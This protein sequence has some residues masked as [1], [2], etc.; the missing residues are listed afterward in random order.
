MPALLMLDRLS[1]LFWLRYIIFR[2]SLTG[3]REVVSTVFRLLVMTGYLFLSI[4]S[5]VTIFLLI[6]LK[7]DQL[8]PLLAGSMGTLFGML[9]FMTLI[10]QATG[11]SANFDPR[12]FMLF[13]ISLRMLFGLNLLS[14]F[15]EAVMITLLPTVAGI[16]LGLG[17]AFDQ[18]LAGFL[19]FLSAAIWLDSIFVLVA[20]ATAWLLS[21]RTRRN[22][23]LFTLLIGAFLVL[24]QVLPRM[25]RAGWGTSLSRLIDP[26]RD[27]LEHALTWTPFGLWQNFFDLLDLGDSRAA[28][29]KLSLVMFLWT[30]SMWALGYALFI[31]LAISP[32]TSASG[33]ASERD[34][35][36]QGH[37]LD[38]KFPFLSDQLST[39][40]GREVT[41][42]LRNTVIWLNTANVLVITLLALP[43]A[44]GARDIAV[45]GPLNLTRNPARAAL[46]WVWMI[47]S[48]TVLINAQYFT[49]IF[50]FDGR[51]FRQYMLAPVRWRRV[52]FGKNLAVW[53]M[54]AAQLA[55]ITICWQLF[56]GGVTP[57]KLYQIVC[58]AIISVSLHTIVGNMVSI[59]FPY[60]AEFG[61]RR[62]RAQETNGMV[63]LFAVFGCGGVVSLALLSTALVAGAVRSELAGHALLTLLALIAI[64]AYWVMLNRHE[65]TLGRRY[66]DIAEILTRKTERF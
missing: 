51:G 19:A 62:R 15:S 16:L 48:Y 39:I 9:V 23:I 55:L 66:F 64:V 20:L 65:R 63:I 58:A 32:R 56:Y 41:Y 49:A 34:R 7:P 43:Q 2:N 46:L 42:L 54:V 13:P 26:W 35:R 17:V 53:G 21:G 37:R 29:G 12:R 8:G 10:T 4:G 40:I 52:L 24:G 14:A 50:A 27:D 47:V 28:Y 33:V 61:I 59:Y 11:T 60:P 57:L 25:I 45:S 36:L 22:E 38:W 3:R 31:R 1:T 6:V 44:G 5:G 18:P 30:G